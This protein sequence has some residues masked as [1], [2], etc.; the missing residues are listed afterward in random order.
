MKGVMVR[1]SIEMKRRLEVMVSEVSNIDLSASKQA[2]HMQ[3]VIHAML[4]SV[5]MQ[6]RPSCIT[7]YTIEAAIKR[8]RRVLQIT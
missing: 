8:P 1:T 6:S 4:P 3:G 5:S 7:A 2:I